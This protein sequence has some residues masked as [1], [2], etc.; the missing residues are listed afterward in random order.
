M[1]C[2]SSL[3]KSGSQSRHPDSKLEATLLIAVIGSSNARWYDGNMF[4]GVREA[5]R[6]VLLS[7]SRIQLLVAPWTVALQASL[8]ITNSQSLL[9]LSPLSQ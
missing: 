9:R 5:N 6:T 1:T 2:Q 8:S 4:L 3:G 7:F